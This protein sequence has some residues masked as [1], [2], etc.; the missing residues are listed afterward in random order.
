MAVEAS[1]RDLDM[2]GKVKMCEGINKSTAEGSN[3]QVDK[4]VY[5]GP[6]RICE[7]AW[8]RP[9]RS[10]TRSCGADLSSSDSS[11]YGFQDISLFMSWPWC[12]GSQVLV[13][14]LNAQ[15]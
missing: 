13:S 11:G 1:A 6:T 15:S 14:G 7:S 8:A 12:L 3:E 4:R 5:D 10:G 2:F 9:A